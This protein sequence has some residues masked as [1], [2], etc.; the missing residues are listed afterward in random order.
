MFFPAFTRIRSQVF[1]WVFKSGFYRKLWSKLNLRKL[2]SSY[3]FTQFLPSEE[4]REKEREGKITML[5]WSWQTLVEQEILQ[6]CAVI[7]L[8]SNVI[9]LDDNESTD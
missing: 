3:N 5:S 4:E 7:I 6:A 8:L 9:E 1:K 2:I